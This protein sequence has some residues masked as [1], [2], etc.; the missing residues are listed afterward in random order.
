MHLP[1]L[2]LAWSCMIAFAQ[3][4]FFVAPIGNIG[5]NGEPAT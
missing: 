2:L 3:S 5:I 4:K 1:I